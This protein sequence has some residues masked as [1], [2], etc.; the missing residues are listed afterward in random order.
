MKIKKFN[1]FISEKKEAQKVEPRI[2]EK[3]QKKA[4]IIPNWKTY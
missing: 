1:K 2:K 4:V 3:K